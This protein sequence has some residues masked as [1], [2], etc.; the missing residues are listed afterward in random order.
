MKYTVYENGKPAVM[1]LKTFKCWEK[2]TFDTKREAEVYAYLWCYPVTK[3][4][5]QQTAPEME[6]GKKYDYGVYEVQ[7]WM[8]IEEEE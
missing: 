8:H 5:A 6:V 7:V 2:A 4:V 3:D 1:A